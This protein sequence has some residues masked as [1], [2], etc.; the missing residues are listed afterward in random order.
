[1]RGCASGCALLLLV[2][3]CGNSTTMS[4][5]EPPA[6]EEPVPAPSDGDGDGLCDVTEDEF[7]TDPAMIDTDGDRLPDLIELV[8]G[9]DATDPESP[10]DDQLGYLEARRESSMDF[11]VRVT[12]DGDGQ[13]FSGY[14]Q[15]LTAIY[16][17]GRSAADFFAGATAVSAYPIDGVRSINEGSAH[18][19]AVLGRTRLAF[20]LRFEYLDE[21]GVLDCKRAYPFRYAIKSDDGVTRAERLYLLIVVPENSIDIAPPR[22]A[23]AM[24][25]T[26]AAGEHCLPQSCQ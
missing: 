18:F 25:L 14:F 2:G 1:M 21:L 24:P 10:F 19:A 15:A 20:S 26:D 7:G 17:D 23:G 6:P 13:G 12:V 9:F 8:N 22:S 4:D 5:A 11:P 3:A 16:A